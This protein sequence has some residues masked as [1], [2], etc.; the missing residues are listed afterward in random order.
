ML[1]NHSKTGSLSSDPT[2]FF[3]FL[4][5]HCVQGLPQEGEGTSTVGA[6]SPSPGYTP[7]QGFN[8][9]EAA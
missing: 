9:L 1:T 3:G 2:F 8:G 6:S 5:G 4:Y 7:I